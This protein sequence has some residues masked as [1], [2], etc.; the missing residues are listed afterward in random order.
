MLTIGET[1]KY[2]GSLY[3]IN[4][5]DIYNKSKELMTW[6]KLPQSNTLLKDLRLNIYIKIRIELCFPLLFDH[7]CIYC[8]FYLHL[9]VFIV[10]A[11]VEEFHWLL[12]Y[13]MIQKS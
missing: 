8:T 12:H 2:Y 10:E 7:F 1:F 6:L 9:W 13:F 5:S 4:K 3:K 11:S